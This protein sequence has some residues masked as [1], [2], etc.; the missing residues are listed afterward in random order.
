M[1]NTNDIRKKIEKLKDISDKRIGEH[2]KEL[3]DQ[4]PLMCHRCS[5]D[6]GIYYGCLKVLDLIPKDYVLVPKEVPWMCPICKDVVMEHLKEIHTFTCPKCDYREWYPMRQ[7]D[8]D[9]SVLVP[10]KNLLTKEEFEDI[11]N[12]YGTHRKWKIIPEKLKYL[13]VERNKINSSVEVKS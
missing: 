2:E 9:N 8:F 11:N 6:T 12:Y 10:K 3:G 5:R 13:T 7:Y 4:H 1:L